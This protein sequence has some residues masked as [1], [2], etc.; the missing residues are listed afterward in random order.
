MDNKYP[1]NIDDLLKVK[2]PKNIPIGNG[3]YRII[4]DY[5][6]YYLKSEILFCITVPNGFSYD[7]AS[8]PRW[9]WSISNLT[10]DGQIRAAAA[11]HDLIYA[12][13]GTLP[14]GLHAMWKNGVWINC[15]GSG[16]SRKDADK[17]FLK[18]MRQ[19]GVGKTDRNRA[20]IFVRL[21]GWLKWGDGI[22]VS[23]MKNCHGIID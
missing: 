4:E 10:P 11:V 22:K 5:R 17:I 9:L 19:T 15:F 2:Q 6:Y 18:I 14:F 3:L 20:Y 16:W 23:S 7:G 8:V 21:F 1:I 13:D 12:Y